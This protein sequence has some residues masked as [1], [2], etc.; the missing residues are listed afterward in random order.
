MIVCTY[1]ISRHHHLSKN[2]Y[3]FSS[4]SH[5]NNKNIELFPP[6]HT[7][8]AKSPPFCVVFSYF[9]PS[10]VL[11][12]TTSIYCLSQRKDII[13]FSI[14]SFIYFIFSFCCC[15]CFALALTANW[16]YLHFPRCNAIT[17]I[18]LDLLL[19]QK[20]FCLSIYNWSNL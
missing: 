12:W 8:L 17:H 5:N 9:N 10:L 11:W 13:K 7:Q 4:Q 18:A 16:T 19:Q 14:Y 20:M 6:P 1:R 3:I 15:L 2:I